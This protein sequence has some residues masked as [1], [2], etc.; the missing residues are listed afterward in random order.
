MLFN[1]ES[2]NQYAKYKLDQRYKEAKHYTLI[3]AILTKRLSTLLRHLAYALE[4]K[5][6]QTQPYGG[7]YVQP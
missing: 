4:D 3:K 5:K 1:D 7:S 6:E 2:A